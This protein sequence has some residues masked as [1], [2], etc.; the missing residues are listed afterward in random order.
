MHTFIILVLMLCF[1]GSLAI[2]YVSMNNQ[3]YIVKPVV[4]NFNIYELDYYLFI[5]SIS[6]CNGSCNFIEDSL[7][8]HVF[9]IK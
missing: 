3:S 1:G 9:L 5:F 6:S 7:L 2:K 4:N 8:E